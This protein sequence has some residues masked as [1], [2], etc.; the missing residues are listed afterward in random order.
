MKK[1]ILEYHMVD[2]VHNDYNNI[3]I[4]PDYFEQQICYLKE[5]CQVVSY[6]DLLCGEDGSG[7]QIAISFDDVFT[8]FKDIV[9]PIINYYQIP[10][11]LF[12]T[13]KYT[14]LNREFWM[15]ELMGLL[16][17]GKDY[18]RE[19]LFQHPM[20]QY[21]FSTA[22]FRER[23]AVYNS[24]KFILGGLGTCERE[25]C[26][27]QIRNWD[28]AG[29]EERKEYLPLSIDF[30][31]TIKNNPLVSFGAHTVSHGML[32]EMTY[33]EQYEEISHSKYYLESELGRDI[34]HFAY[35][36]GSYNNSTKAILKKLNFK[37]ACSSRKGWWEDKRTDFLELPR[38]VPP[39]A[40][41][42]GFERWMRMLCDEEKES[43][44]NE[45]VV[46]IGK[47]EG[48]KRACG[49][50][51]KSVIFG[52]GIFGEI[53]L[54][55]MQQLEMQ[56]DLI[57][58][59]DNDLRKQGKTFHEYPVFSVDLLKDGGYEVYIWHYSRTILAQLKEMN[60]RNIHLITG[61]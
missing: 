41:K 58:F 59:V 34:Q 30:C 4:C 29:Y 2:E 33:E 51:R 5:H 61:V 55:R 17:E 52:A 50:E 3:N 11:I 1:I 46:Y 42:E 38:L 32:G 49:R 8:G 35:P 7:T 24:L 22:N 18:K 57:G 13:E 21:K 39:N 31:K 26:M 36:F 27:E 48:D 37:S 20:Y 12:L 45:F 25:S 47:L 14:M 23:E 15:N 60:V 56:A 10:V 43:A 40:G 53:L 28:S 9:Y 19:F 6:E 44:A 54:Y 16:L